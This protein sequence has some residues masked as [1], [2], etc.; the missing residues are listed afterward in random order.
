MLSML[1][2]GLSVGLAEESP[3]PLN[4]SAD[5]SVY[6]G[7]WALNG[8]AIS[9]I[10]AGVPLSIASEDPYAKAFHQMNA[11]WNVVNLA[12]A[13]GSLILDKPAEPKRLA[14]IFWIN[15]GLDVAYVAAGLAMAHH[16]RETHDPKLEGWGNSIALQGGFLFGFDAVMGWRMQ[17]YIK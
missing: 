3:E 8:W 15:A 9:N 4:R 7:M 10:A 6:R 17:S 16:G 5:V 12:L 2:L 11:G 14:K 1:L 13:S